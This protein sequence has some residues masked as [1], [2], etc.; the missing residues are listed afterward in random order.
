MI[1]KHAAQYGVKWDQ[2]LCYL[3]FAYRVKP[4]SSTGELPFFLVYGQDARLRIPALLSQ[5]RT[6]YQVDVEDYRVEMTSGL[7]TAW[8]DAQH[9]IEKSQTRYKHQYDKKAK[10]AHYKVG[11]RIFIH[12]PHET[13]GKYRKLAHPFHGLYRVQAVT[14]TDVRA[15]P[16]DDPDAEPIFVHLSRVRPCYKELPNV[17]WTRKPRRK[18]C[19][20]LPR[21]LEPQNLQP[22]VHPYHLHS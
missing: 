18:A 4:H 5:P 11:D 1:A 9:H 15:V 10:K 2:Y 13:T 8:R 3:L 12:M 16:V 7:T 22:V 17:S 19:W 20:R 14:N 21:G 6:A